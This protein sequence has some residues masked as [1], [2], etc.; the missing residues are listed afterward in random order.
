MS[1]MRTFAVLLAVSLASVAPASAQTRSARD[2]ALAEETIS[3]PTSSP[4][5]IAPTEP[6][7]IARSTAGRAGDRQTFEETLGNPGR[8]IESR[9]NTRISSRLRNRI[10][11]NY[12]LPSTPTAAIEAAE[13]SLRAGRR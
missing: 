2:A 3:Q 4:T 13:D 8:R 5:S 11:R 1:P 7:R 9:I 6:G 12:Q 10:D